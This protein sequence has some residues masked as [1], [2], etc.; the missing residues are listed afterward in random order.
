MALVEIVS[1]Q[2]AFCVWSVQHFN[3]EGE[4]WDVVM[5]MNHSYY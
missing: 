5:M 3:N 2:S 1:L 4:K